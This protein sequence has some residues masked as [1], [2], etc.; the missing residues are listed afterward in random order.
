M[1]LS[2]VLRSSKGQFREKYPEA[3]KSRGEHRSNAVGWQ[4]PGPGSP[5]ARASTL[6]HFLTKVNKGIPNLFP[7]AHPRTQRH[8][9]P[10]GLERHPMAFSSSCWLS[11]QTLKKISTTEAE[12]VAQ[13]WNTH[14]ACVSTW[15]PIPA[16]KE[17][18][19]F[20]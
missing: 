3:S 5:K 11:T 20:Y 14:L 4:P 17:I 16:F 8:F 12:A 1:V 18:S 13:R 2:L 7:L 15:I 10:M 6:P 19:F 9:C